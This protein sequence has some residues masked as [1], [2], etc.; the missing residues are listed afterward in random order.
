MPL[1]SITFKDLV[2]QV[3][4]HLVERIERGQW[5]EWLPGERDLADELRVSRKTIRRA[6]GYLVRLGQIETV[7]S[8]GHR[9]A[10]GK[11]RA[12][13]AAATTER[14]ATILCP[15]PLENLRPYTALWG[16]HL[17]TQLHGSGIK[18]RWQAAP[19]CYTR[20]PSGA[21]AKLTET[22]P[23]SCWI[24]THS[25]RSIQQWFVNSGIPC[26]VSGSTHEGIRLPSMDVDHF[27]LCRHAAGVF[28]RNGHRNVA[29]LTEHTNR[30]GELESERGF[31]AGMQ[32]A[33]PPGSVE[34]IHHDRSRESIIGALQRLLRSPRRPTAL[35]V[36]QPVVYVSVMSLLARHRL[37]IPH[38]L[39]VL[40]RD[41]DPIFRYL[42]PRP[43]HYTYPPEKFARRMAMLVLKTANARDGSPETIRCT[44]TYVP[45]DTLRDLNER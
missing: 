33:T 5:E 24:L 9:I 11:T 14:V 15:E 28:A 34:V 12:R 36:A 37:R 43:G 45:G 32:A 20:Q 4:D 2:A 39:S 35:F 23:S 44:P 10:R 3:T 21:L 13:R 8:R 1:R 30:A 25:T 22:H 16:G 42:E 31:I 18:V 27:G 41:A 17:Q 26:V 6:L 19:K 38:D 40:C 29:F 7:A